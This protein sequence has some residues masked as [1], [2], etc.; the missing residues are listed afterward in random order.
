[1]SRPRL[2]SGTV[3]EF[4]GVRGWGAIRSVTGTEHFFH[5]TEIADGSRSIVP[6]TAVRFQVVAGR[7]GWWEAAAVEPSPGQ[8]P[9][10]GS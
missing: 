1:L 10:S 2:I 4:D 7:L 8:D 6:G 9:P 5:C 3:T